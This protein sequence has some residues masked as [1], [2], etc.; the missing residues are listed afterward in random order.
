[1]VRSSSSSP[2]RRNA[3]TR[4]LAAL[5]TWMTTHPWLSFGLAMVAT[6]GFTYAASQLDIRTNIEDLFP[7]NTPRVTRAKAAR[8]KLARSSQILLVISSPDREANER[9]ANDLSVRLEADDL[10]DSVDLKHDVSFFRKNALLFLPPEELQSID[11]KLKRSIKRAVARDLD[12]FDG[13]ATGDI[14]EESDDDLDEDFGEEGNEIDEEFGED[15]E[16]DEGFGEAPDAEAEVAICSPSSEGG[17]CEADGED[18]GISLPDEDEIREKYG[19]ANLS[20]YLSNSEGTLYGIKA[21]PTFSA[22]QVGRSKKLLSHLEEI[23]AELD[24]ASYHPEM[25]WIMEGDYHKKIEEIEVIRSDLSKAS[26]F[27]LA[28]ILVLVALYF[29][30]FR[31]VLFVFVPLLSGLAWT[32]G[33]AWLTV[34]YLNLITAFIFAIMFGLGVDFAVHAVNRYMEGREQGKEVE[35]ALVDGLMHLGRPMVSA[36][37]TTTITFLSLVIFDFRG[38]S[39]FGLIA[40]LGV[41]ICLLVVYLIFPS[42]T[43]ILHRIRPEKPPRKPRFSSNST[44]IFFGSRRKALVVV[45]GFLGAVMLL[46]PG[47]S[48]VGFEQDMKKV[49][50]KAKETDRSRLMRRFR[51]EVEGR[52]TS[53]VILLTKSREETRKVH[54]FLIEH[55]GEYAYIQDYASIYSFV[56]DN[57]AERQ[58]IVQR[59]HERLRK[60]M[61]ALTG[62]DL[63]SAQEA[64][65]YLTPELFDE[66]DLPDWVLAR[67]T[68]KDGNIG[69]FVT[70]YAHG[71]KAHA[72]DVGGILDE[73]DPLVIDGTPYPTTASYYILRDAYDIVLGEG[74]IAVGLAALAV[75]LLLFI[76]F[77]TLREVAAA[78]LPLF[79]GVVAYLG[80]MGWTGQDINMF[81]MV[82]LP[83]V[84]GIGIDSSIHLVHRVREEGAHRMSLIANTTGSAAGMSAATT[85]IG[86]GSLALAS[87]PGLRS[88]GVL[89]PVGIILCYLSSVLLTCSLSTLWQRGDNR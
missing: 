45:A 24:P 47:A 1:M 23:V 83:T 32:M 13:G 6:A 58:A 50:T 60:K 27:A 41:P 79:L 25:E 11:A 4:A 9:F 72:A 75:L 84:F 81:N 51:R 43:V 35:Q 28:M 62:E 55:S 21:Y 40:G 76:D 42:L 34:G 29:G 49:M 31:A 68:D 22:S 86:F 61:G 59:M 46:A 69:H 48:S 10:I 15:E 8:D 53:P 7:E 57:Q 39:Q 56:P 65:P 73:L 19:L 64:M 77:R 33:M 14:A 38:F 52:S 88:I 80:Y 82:I 37:I 5:L 3:L 17:N 67:F 87:N 63:K 20:E 74:P 54:D 16:L 18:D 89:A 30:N 85:A 78:F 2:H 71:H 26:L 36:A 70:L 44:S 12:P 66:L